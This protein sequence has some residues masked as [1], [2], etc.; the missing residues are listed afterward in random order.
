[1]TQKIIMSLMLTLLS[2][3]LFGCTPI[4]DAIKN[5]GPIKKSEA[6]RYG[7]DGGIDVEN[8]SK[9]IEA[10][11]LY[12][13]KFAHSAGLIKIPDPVP[14]NI[15]NS[16]KDWESVAY[17]GFIYVNQ[18]CTGYIGELYNYQDG[19]ERSRKAA[20]NQVVG[21][22][23]AASA[24]AGV[25][26]ASSQFL[27]YIA[28][29]F[30]LVSLT[31]NNIFDYFAVRYTP[32]AAKEVTDKLYSDLRKSLRDNPGAITTRYAA[33][34]F[35]QRSITVCMPFTIEAITTKSAQT[36]KIEGGTVQSASSPGTLPSGT[37]NTKPEPSQTPTPRQPGTETG[38]SLFFAPQSVRVN[39]K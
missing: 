14:T 37:S 35:I 10:Q 5:F 9:A 3:Y 7:L 12:L 24:V 17:G 18:L 26:G 4:D 21:T 31:T 27:T 39:D 32:G 13:A 33:V 16:V 8:L 34:D 1:M 29:A 30:G 20:T 38:N 15:N 23:T 6:A 22:G 36:A 2:N 11:D 19:Y 28:T 25:A